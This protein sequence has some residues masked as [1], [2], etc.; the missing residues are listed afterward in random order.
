MADAPEFVDFEVDGDFEAA[1]EFGGGFS[2][3]PPG[4]YIL[5]IDNIQQKTFSSNNAGFVVTFKVSEGQ[6]N[7]EAAKQTGRLLFGNYVLTDKA[8]GR[9]KQLMIACGAPLDKFRASACMGA[10]IRAEVIHNEGKPDVGPDGQPRDAKTFA[11]VINEMPLDATPAQDEAP[12][13]PPPSTKKAA[14]TT[15]AANGKAPA[16]GA[17]R[18]T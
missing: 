16:A 12:P 3:V 9:V 6:E 8:L 7:D 5:D 10:K 17:A 13:P 4:K 15:P 14:A 1:K 11:N 2:N 18:R